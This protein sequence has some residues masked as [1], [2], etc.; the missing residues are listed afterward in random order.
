MAM[1]VMWNPAT[2]GVFITPAIHMSEVVFD[3]DMPRKQ[4]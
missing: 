2:S 4:L 3:S 1:L